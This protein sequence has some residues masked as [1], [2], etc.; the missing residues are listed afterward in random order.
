MFMDGNFVSKSSIPD[1]SPQES[2]S[3]SLGVDPSVKITYHPQQKVVRTQGGYIISTS[4][5]QEVTRFSQRISIKN[6]RPSGL[7]RLVVQDRV[8]NSEDS[9]IKVTLLQPDEKFIGAPSNSYTAS[10]NKSVSSVNTEKLSHAV[11]KGVRAQW[12]QKNYEEIEG[13]GGARGDGVIEWI[14]TGLESS[15][16]LDLEYE[17]SSPYGVRWY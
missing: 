1:V 3:C 17:V 8:P 14:C 13:T 6:T 9:R 15:V 4:S 7:P 2:F 12:A 10:A 16:N 5:K 11:Q